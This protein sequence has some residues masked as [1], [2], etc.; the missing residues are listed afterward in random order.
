MEARELH[1]L[2]LVV[3]NKTLSALFPGS[4]S[5]SSIVVTEGVVAVREVEE[6]EVVSWAGKVSHVL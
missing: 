6:G 2:A 3:N 1:E 5:Y 4:H